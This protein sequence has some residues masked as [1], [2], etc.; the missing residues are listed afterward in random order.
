MHGQQ[1]IKKKKNFKLVSSIKFCLNETCNK[2]RIE[3]YLSDTF[4]IKWS[5]KKGGFNEIDNYQFRF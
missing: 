5:E 1:N 4:P 2:V 3:R